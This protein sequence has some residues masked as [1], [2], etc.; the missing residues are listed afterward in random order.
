MS[1]YD[2]L[3]KNNFLIPRTS[4]KVEKKIAFTMQIDKGFQ[5]ESYIS[6][7]QDMIVD[8]SVMPDLKLDNYIKETS[9]DSNGVSRYDSWES[10]KRDLLPILRKSSIPFKVSLFKD[11]K[12]ELDIA[13]LN[14]IIK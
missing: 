4:K 10:F 2:R 1:Q 6:I 12:Q 8:I 11:S 7:L 13:I 5:I 14:T 3:T 9:K